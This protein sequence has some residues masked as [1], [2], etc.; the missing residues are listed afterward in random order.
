V[1]VYDIRGNSLTDLKDEDE[2]ETKATP[3]SEP[4]TGSKA[5]PPKEERVSNRAKDDVRKNFSRGFSMEEIVKAKPAA[6]DEEEDTTKV[7]RKPMKRGFTKPAKI[8]KVK[9]INV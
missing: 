6:A 1:E 8:N 2:E 3:G 9:L 4:K 5:S 7:K